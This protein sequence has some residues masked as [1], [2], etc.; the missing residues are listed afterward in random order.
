MS[1]TQPT[2]RMSQKETEETKRHILFLFVVIVLLLHI[3]FEC[4][5][6][7]YSMFIGYIIMSHVAEL[8]NDILFPVEVEYVIHDKNE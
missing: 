6:D 3:A 8:I 5:I 1:S 2:V 4:S 7:P